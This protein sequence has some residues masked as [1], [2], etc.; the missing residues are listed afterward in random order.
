MVTEDITDFGSGWEMLTLTNLNYMKERIQILD[1]VF[2][3]VIS[4]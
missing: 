1:S 4:S 3:I 2:H